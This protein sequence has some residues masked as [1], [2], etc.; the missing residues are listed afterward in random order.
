MKKIICT[1]TSDPIYDQ[2]MNRICHSL[3]EHGYEVTLIGRR[4]KDTNHVPNTS[5]TCKRLQ[6][7]F[8]KGKLFYA[9]INIRLFIALLFR[10]TD[11]ICAVDLDTILPAYWVSIIKRKLFIYDSHE[12]F[13]EQAEIVDRP[14]IHA[15]WSKVEAKILPKTKFA[16]TVCQSIADIYNKKYKSNFKVIRNVPESM[17]QPDENVKKSKNLVYVGAVNKGRGLEV[18][19]KGMKDIDSQLYIC[20]Y[21]DI[22]SN[23]KK[24][25][26]DEGVEN[27]VIFTGALLPEQIREYARNSYIGVLLLEKVSLSY[28]YSLSNKFFEYMH[29]G[30]PQITIDFPEY[31]RI[32]QQ[33]ELAKLISLDTQAFVEA[34]NA[35]LKNQEEYHSLSSNALLAAKEFNWETEKNKLCQFYDAIFQ[36]SKKN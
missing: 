21:G 15:F 16:Y 32:N 3:A 12:Y 17:S 6:L 9:E 10:K 25:A 36:L 29:A 31:N 35:L 7:C 14:R 24:L 34:A 5:F 8:S 18:C 30:I 33:Y 26:K 11:A 20:G 23:L 19:I 27:K 28:Y 1:V 4:I 13:T 2:R 22:L